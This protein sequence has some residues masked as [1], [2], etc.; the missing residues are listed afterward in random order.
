MKKNFYILAT[1]LLSILSFKSNA[2]HLVGSD[3]SYKCT[4]TPNLYTVTLKIYRDCSGIPLCSGC[5]NAIP[6]GTV[7][8]CTTSSS[9]WSTQIVG[10]S[11]GCAGINFG[12]FTLN[13]VQ[14]SS[15][16]DIIQTCNSV[17]TI[18]TNCNTRTAGSFSPGIEIYTYTGNVDLSGVPTSCC[19][20]T[21]GANTCC[22]NSATNTTSSL[23]FQTVCTINRCQT[24]CNSAPTFTNDAV[25]IICSGVDFIYNL[26]AMDPDGDSLSYAFGQSLQGIGSPVSYITPY[27]ATYPFPYFGAPNTTAAYPAGLRIDPLTGDVLF[28]PMGQFVSYLVIEVTQWK[29]VSGVRVNVGM[30][31]RDVQFISQLCN[32]NRAP[33][34][35]TYKNGILQ[36]GFQN[37]VIAGQQI[38]IDIV[39]QDQQ[40]LTT[41]PQIVADTTDLKWNNPGLY[42]PIMANATFTRNY[43]IANRGI[44]GPKADSFKFCWTPPLNAARNEPYLF[45]VTGS[46][47][48]CPLR[49]LATR[50]ITI[51][52]DSAKTILINN[53]TKNSYCNNIITPTNVYYNTTR[54]NINSGNVFTVQLSDSS[55]SFT[56]ATNIGTK[57]SIDSIG[58]IPVVVPIGLFCLNE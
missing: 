11:S 53:I 15:G 6:N 33:L 34:I 57:A 40:D 52:V 45:T 48:F 28:R 41:S 24:P 3:I 55:G 51:K 10:A 13:A 56:N 17:Q 46:D 26:G 21:L 47:R 44:N 32:S 1:I 49:S 12:S 9:G 25:A 27:S 8:N 50:G 43:I 16:F 4:S 23:N 42:V 7:A 58:F 29:L 14:T 5:T 38:C 35:K 36:N 30:T 31:R 20:V 2:T 19:N 39:A 37:T 22:R 54:V 18:C